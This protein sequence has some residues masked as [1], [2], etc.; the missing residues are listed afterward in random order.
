MCLNKFGNG[1]LLVGGPALRRFP[2]LSALSA[3]QLFSQ[4]AA[5]PRKSKIGQKR[6]WIVNAKDA[7]LPL[8][9][10]GCSET[11]S[12][13]PNATGRTTTRPEA[14]ILIAHPSPHLRHG[15]PDIGS[16][17]GRVGSRERYFLQGHIRLG[18]RS[19]HWQGRPHRKPCPPRQA[20]SGTC[21]S[22]EAFKR[23]VR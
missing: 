5:K 20:G 9:T 14:P 6:Q 17:P 21:L 10:G 8:L 3:L 11:R 1:V 4:I 12:V 16:S 23:Q 18:P 22:F 19:C 2:K 15:S 13:S 7:E